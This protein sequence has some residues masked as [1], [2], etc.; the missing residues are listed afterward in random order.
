MT[1]VI[2]E[3]K[4]R[5]SLTFFQHLLDSYRTYLLRFS[6]NS[7]WYI[8]LFLYK[9]LL[10]S[11]YKQS[12]FCIPC[13]KSAVSADEL[14]SEALSK[15]K[16]TRKKSNQSNA[17]LFREARECQMHEMVTSVEFA[18]ETRCINTGLTFSFRSLGSLKEVRTWFYLSQR[19]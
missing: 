10:N 3:K 19:S 13:L 1:A 4:R 7:S 5:M 14:R 11:L 6:S 9:S 8:Y 12:Y 16:L 2:T 15:Y 18:P 17:G